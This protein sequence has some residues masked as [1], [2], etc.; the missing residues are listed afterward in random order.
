MW[1]HWELVPSE[2]EEM[3][4]NHNKSHQVHPGIRTPGNSFGVLDPFGGKD[5]KGV[6]VRN[7]EREG[8]K[9]VDL[10]R[11]SEGSPSAA[12]LT[13]KLSA[14]RIPHWTGFTPTGLYPSYLRPLANIALLFLVVPVLLALSLPVALINLLAFRDP[15]L[16]FFTQERMGQ[17]GRTFRIYK[18]R[19]MRPIEGN[20]FEAWGSGD[21]NRVTGFGRFLRSTHLDE[22][23]QILNILKGDMDFIGPRPEM[24]EIH[25]WA[26]ANIEG[27][28]RRLVLRPGITGLAQ[29]TQGY[30]GQCEVAYAKKLDADDVYRV[31]ISAL[32]DLSILIRTVAWMMCGKG[33]SW[34]KRIRSISE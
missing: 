11:F 3:T 33:W 26:V 10:M 5:M 15:R 9:L 24:V 1:K 22:I 12:A 20:S 6:D 19:T 23:P 18:F 25:E 14:S 28:E 7:A 8:L 30:T 13:K 4:R 31:N 21:R 32:M 27:F 29:I 17:F 34:D 16:V 2:V